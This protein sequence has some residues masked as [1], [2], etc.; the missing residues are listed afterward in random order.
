MAMPFLFVP[1][2][3]M[4]LGAFRGE[5]LGQVAG[6]QNFFRQIGGSIGISSLDTLLTRAGAQHYNDLMGHVT[7]M[8]PMALQALKQATTL[9]AVKMA[10]QF[11]IEAPMRL[12]TA[13]LYGRTMSQSFILSFDQLCYVV[14]AVVALGLIPLYL[15]KPG[16]ASGPVMD[17]H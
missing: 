3:Q 4:V 10:S 12:G 2:N 1:I 11:G 7:A 14:M 5:E 13:T 15:I 9:P 17:V 8:D 6:M 16:K